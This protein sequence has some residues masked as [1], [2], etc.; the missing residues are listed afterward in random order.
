MPRPIRLSAPNTTYHIIIRCNNSQPLISSHSDFRL[1]INILALYK[2]KFNFKLFAYCVMNTH[3]HLIIQTPLNPNYSISKIMHAILWRFAFSYNRFHNRKGHFFNDRFK[4]LIVQS[5]V[6]GLTLLKYISQNPLRAGIVKKCDEYMWS[7]YRVY[8]D[9]V[10]D[11]LIDLLPSFL[12]LSARRKIAS[13]MFREMVE[14][15]V[16]A[17]DEVWS[18]GYVIGDRGFVLDV[19]SKFGL[20]NSK[21]PG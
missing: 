21:P 1:L 13:R 19:L 11:P 18:K 14:S 2:A 3:I 10:Y 12:G 7:S 15:S 9:G 8:S 4:S 16:M 20:L 6:Y 5:D 17:K